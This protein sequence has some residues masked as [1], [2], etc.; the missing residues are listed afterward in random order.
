MTPE[1][2]QAELRSDSHGVPWPTRETASR[3]RVERTVAF[4]GNPGFRRYPR[5]TSM[6]LALLDAVRRSGQIRTRD[7]DDVTDDERCDDPSCIICHETR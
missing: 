5:P 6:G 4:G 2:V 7:D 3:P 1:Q